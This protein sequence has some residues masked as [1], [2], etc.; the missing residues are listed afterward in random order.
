[1][2]NPVPVTFHRLGASSGHWPT[3]VPGSPSRGRETL[4]ARLPIV[5]KEAEA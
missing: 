1:M 5:P 2:R 4:G 3:V